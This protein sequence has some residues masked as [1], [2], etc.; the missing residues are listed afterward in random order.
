MWSNSDASLRF[1][2]GA[3]LFVTLYA[4]DV[5]D[6]KVPNGQQALSAQ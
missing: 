1:H 6:R 5:S 3:L 4:A 2:E